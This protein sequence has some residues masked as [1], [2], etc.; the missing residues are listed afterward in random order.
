MPDVI[1]VAN[2]QEAVELAQSFKAKGRYNWFRGQV[3][4]W[5]PLSSLFRLRRDADESAFERVQTRYKLF[6]EWLSENVD[7]KYLL[8]AGN[9]HQFFAVAQHYGIPTDYIDFTTDPAV[10]GF[11][12]ADTET[13]P[14]GGMSCIYCLDTKDLLDLWKS[15][16][17]VRKEPTIE[18]VEVDVTNLW[19]L[20]AQRGVFLH[21][22]YN[23][24]VD[25]PMD[26]IVF[27]YT[28]YPAYP[29]KDYI[30]PKNRSALE[31]QLDQHFDLEKRHF[32]HEEM[33]E[34]LEKLRM[35]GRQVSFHRMREHDGGFYRE[36]FINPDTLTPLTSWDAT[37]RW[38]AYPIEHFHA[39]DTGAERIRL[40]GGDRSSVETAIKFGVKQIL[41]TKPGIRAKLIEWRFEGATGGL[42][43]ELI[44]TM[45][46]YAWDGMRSL[47]FSNAQIATTFSAIAGLVSAGFCADPDVASSM[48]RFSE[49]SGGNAIRI[50]FGYADNSSSIGYTTTE[51]LQHAMRDDLLG[52]VTSEYRDRLGDFHIVFQLIQKPSLLFE[53][54]P[55]TE[56]FVRDLIPSQIVSERMPT[57]FNPGMITRFGRP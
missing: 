41:D 37:S 34:M 15:L 50:E 25:Y 32:G 49:I 44:S 39:L 22:N 52:M 26:R 10:A 36:A 21:A 55:V 40:N 16:K 35:K 13:P 7:L 43:T 56:I 8:E 9:E 5:P 23:W 47:P 42:P 38:L 3:R 30:Y 54:E 24:D 18:A 2:V 12:A 20:H 51:S 28:G 53:F 19:R 29:A 17:V 14:D 1:P 27:P 45:L 11:F 48:R 4:D 33:V 46:Q 31:L 57:L 6:M